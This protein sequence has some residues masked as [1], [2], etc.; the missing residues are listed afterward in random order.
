M[1]FT[2]IPATLKIQMAF[3]PTFNAVSLFTGSKLRHYTRPYARGL[4]T[5]KIAAFSRTPLDQPVR[6]SLKA[7]LRNSHDSRSSKAQR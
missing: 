7:L 2:R 5:S 3:S 1:V 6:N 4:A